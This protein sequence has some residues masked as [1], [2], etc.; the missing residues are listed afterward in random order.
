MPKPIPDSFED[1]ALW[2]RAEQLAETLL[3]VRDRVW[4]VPCVW[5][6]AN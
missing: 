6:F 2:A 3:D 1:K 4:R 5:A